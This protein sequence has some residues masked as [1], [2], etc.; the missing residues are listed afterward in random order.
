[1]K[2][3]KYKKIERNLKIIDKIMFY[4]LTIICILYNIIQLILLHNS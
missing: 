4:G 1:M 3:Q 2:K